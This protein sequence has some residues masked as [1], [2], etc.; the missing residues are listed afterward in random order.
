MSLL[1]CFQ[2]PPDALGV[3]LDFAVAKEV[4]NPQVALRIGMSPF[5]CGCKEYYSV[6]VILFLKMGD[7]QV[8]LPLGFHVANK[9]LQF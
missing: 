1:G 8:G 7:S 2:K 5:G 3:V 6:V 4:A 9:G